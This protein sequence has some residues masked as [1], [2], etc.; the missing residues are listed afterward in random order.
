MQFLKK[1]IIFQYWQ[2]NFFFFI[3][4]KPCLTNIS[5]I[6]FQKNLWE[7]SSFILS[8]VRFCLP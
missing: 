8:Y 4:G 1:E 2:S 5:N 6:I 3:K 7:K